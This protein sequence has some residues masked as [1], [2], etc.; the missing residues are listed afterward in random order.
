MKPGE[1]EQKLA[2]E[3]VTRRNVIAV[4]SHSNETRKLLNELTEK[5]QS[6]QDLIMS[7]DTQI[8]LLKKQIVVLQTKIFAGGTSN[9]SN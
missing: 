7:R 1:K 4:V 2:F 9:I 6:L 8:N 5:V 3:E